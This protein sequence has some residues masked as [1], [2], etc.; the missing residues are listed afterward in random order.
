VLD[1]RPTGD[2]DEWLGGKTDRSVAG[3]DDGDDTE[4]L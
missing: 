3:G 4:P 1:H 2:L